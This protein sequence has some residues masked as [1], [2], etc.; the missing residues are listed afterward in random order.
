MKTFDVSVNVLNT[1]VVWKQ[2]NTLESSHISVHQ[3]A[4]HLNQQLTQPLT[5]PLNQQS[6]HALT[7]QPNQLAHQTANQQPTQTTLTAT[8]IVCTW[9]RPAHLKLE[10]IFLTL[11]FFVLM[12]LVVTFQ[13]NTNVHILSTLIGSSLVL[14]TPAVF[15]V[16]HSRR[17]RVEKQNYVHMFLLHGAGVLAIL[18]TSYVS[19]VFIVFCA[20]FAH[21]LQQSTTQK[22][23]SR[24]TGIC[25]I[26]LVLN[27]VAI[28][29]LQQQTAES[30][31]HFHIVCSIIAILSISVYIVY[32]FIEYAPTR[33]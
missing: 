18:Q 16:W 6:T 13:Q 1:N 14:T 8:D 22:L 5:Q 15:V 23:N 19:V 21:V 26:M 27:G 31:W 12:S 4:S 7:Q 33:V 9:H 17:W 28:I 11:P 24:N 29:L 32:T 10:M 20:V 3:N 2:R 30:S 25:A